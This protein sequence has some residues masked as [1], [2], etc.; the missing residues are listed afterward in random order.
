E[1]EPRAL[2]V[3]EACRLERL[4][5][6]RVAP[7]ALAGIEQV[8][9][10]RARVAIAAIRLRRAEHELR[11]GV[12]L[13]AHDLG[14]GA[15]RREA[16]VLAVA[17]VELHRRQRGLPRRR[18]MAALACEHVAACEAVHRIAVTRAAYTIGAH[19]RGDALRIGCAMTALARRGRVRAVE[20]P[21]GEVV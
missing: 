12:T 17:G 14:V 8:P 9:R 16:G 13:D 6:R 18:Q 19:V 4:E 21:A 11:A 3:I 2:E 5:R 20:R 7:R 1:I 15:E 10:V